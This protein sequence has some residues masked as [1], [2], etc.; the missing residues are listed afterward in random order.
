MKTTTDPGEAFHPEVKAAFEDLIAAE[1]SANCL[2][3]LLLFVPVI[4]SCIN[5]AYLAGHRDARYE[6]N[7][8][9]KGETQ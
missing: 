5:S 2:T 9:A 8:S 7:A 1:P 6:A 4:E 3:V